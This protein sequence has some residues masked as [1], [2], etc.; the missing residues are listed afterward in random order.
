[1]SWHSLRGAGGCVGLCP[2][3]RASW[4][5][6]YLVPCGPDSSMTGQKSVTSCQSV[7]WHEGEWVG[8]EVLGMRE[9]FGSRRHER[10]EA[11]EARSTRRGWLQS[12][13]PARALCFVRFALRVFVVP[14]CLRGPDSIITG[15]KIRY[16]L[17]IRVLA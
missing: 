5:R 15:Q 9:G 1:M 17:H 6:G 4:V 16:I 7:F 11:H 10:G 2:G 3:L 13:F 8:A 14:S 12:A